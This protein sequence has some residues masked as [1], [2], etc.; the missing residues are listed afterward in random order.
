M[1][2]AA[3]SMDGW[4]D[5][6]VRPY[7]ESDPDGFEKV[8]IDGGPAGVVI[9][10]GP[11]RDGGPSRWIGGPEAALAPHGRGRGW[12]MIGDAARRRTV[13]E[14]LAATGEPEASDS[15]PGLRAVVRALLGREA[16]NAMVSIPDLPEWDEA[17]RSE[18]LDALG[19]RLRDESRSPRPTLL[20]RSVAVVH[21]ALAARH[22]LPQPG[23]RITTIAHDHGGLEVQ[24]FVLAEATGH[25]GHVAPLR[26]HF[27]HRIA[28]HFGLSTLA[29]TIDAGLAVQHP[30][31]A[32][33]RLEDRRLGALVLLGEQL[34]PVLRRDGGTWFR[35]SGD[36]CFENPHLDQIAIPDVGDD[37]LVVTP[38]HGLWRDVLRAA[39]PPAIFLTPMDIA[40]GAYEAAQLVAAGLPHYLQR[41]EPVRLAVRGRDEPEWADL[42]PDGANA[43]ANAVHDAPL[44]NALRWPDAA[45]RIAFSLLRGTTEVRSVE[46]VREGVPAGPVTIRIRQ[47]PGQ[48]FAEVEVGAVGGPLRVDPIR[49][50]WN[51]L[52]PDPRSPEQVLDDL[53]EP[54][55]AVPDRYAEV[56]H[57]AAWEATGQ[58]PALMEV[59]RREEPGPIYDV[60]RTVVLHGPGGIHLNGRF[61]CVGT[62]GDVP[63]GF[64]ERSVTLDTWLMRAAGEVARQMAAPHAGALPNRWFLAASWCYTRCPES[65]QDVALTA[66]EARAARRRHPA[67][68]YKADGIILPQAAGRTI[69]DPARLER[70]IE[71]ML[72][73]P[74]WSN[75]DVAALAFALGRREAAPALLTPNV[76]ARIGRRLVDE[77]RSTAGSEKVG[78]RL[79]YQLRL[80]A[81]LLRAR[82]AA[83]RA[84]LAGREPVAE[85]I[86]DAL[87]ACISRKHP[88]RCESRAIGRA[89]DQAP[90]LV[91]MLR[92][93][94]GRTDVIS[95]L[96]RVDR[97]E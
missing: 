2:W 20:W 24:T 81:G 25:A 30:E 65:I 38:A 55:P 61:W 23:R 39:L 88:Q 63:E 96:E 53:R 16:R 37:L 68:G 46:A 8:E 49:L 12:G 94:G 79:V 73:L 93:E 57:P 50:H 74:D 11:Q 78:Y 34:P 97:D 14:L 52:P 13:C 95:A 29:R 92:G 22:V 17:R 75:H 42:I 19:A 90:E 48:S 28:P 33:G 26:E 7:G 91:A 35:L 4:R 54:V 89:L 47:E 43:P 6:A 82:E 18:L 21:A 36:V 32:E 41:L 66:L 40:R 72:A 31:L 86:A 77:L 10:R 51:D 71:A 69:S 58:K 59:L 67:H 64:A 62:D 84:L 3:L 5:A 1:S 87:Q 80:V 83:P 9:D 56:S 70:L 15:G 45:E 76:R 60:L 27:G 44:E 85:G